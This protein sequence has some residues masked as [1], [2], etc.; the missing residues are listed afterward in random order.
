MTRLQFIAFG[1]TSV[2]LISVVLLSIRDRRGKVSIG[3]LALL[4]AQI[5]GLVG[6]VALAYRSA[7][8]REA[9]NLQRPYASTEWTRLAPFTDID[10]DGPPGNPYV[11]VNGEWYE[12]KAIAGI[13]MEKVQAF[14]V[15]EYG[16]LPLAQK[17]IAEDPYDVLVAMGIDHP[18]TVSMTVQRIESGVIVELSDVA[19]TA[20]NRQQ[21]YQ[22]RYAS[23][24]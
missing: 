7:W 14:A 18:A 16:G 10:W 21:V 20:E 13:P 5:V 2:G 1:L 9:S 3:T 6:Y 24:G 11:L 8:S 12:L 4:L 23:G 17:R 22:N 15:K 19:M